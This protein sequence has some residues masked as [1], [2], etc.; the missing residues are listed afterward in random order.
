MV[1]KVGVGGHS[2]DAVGLQMA[3]W[4]DH[5]PGS[6]PLRVCALW[7][8]VVIVLYPFCRWVAAVKARRRDWWLSY[9]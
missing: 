3:R 9:V 8:V 5:G 1:R 4:P 7:A 6:S 2:R